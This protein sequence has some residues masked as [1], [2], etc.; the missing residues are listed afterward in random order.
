VVKTDKLNTTLYEQAP[1]KSDYAN[2]N[3]DS[4]KGMVEKEDSLV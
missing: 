4:I 1:T 3:L 2:E